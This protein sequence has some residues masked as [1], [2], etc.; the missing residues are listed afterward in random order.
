MF[1]LLLL[2]KKSKRTRKGEGE[3]G[4]VTQAK[5]HEVDFFICVYCKKSDFDSAYYIWDF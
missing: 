3:V 2:W 5:S 1:G 4:G